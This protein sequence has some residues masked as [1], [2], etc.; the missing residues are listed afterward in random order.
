M[1]SVLATV[2]LLLATVCTAVAAT[3][4][5]AHEHVLNRARVG[6]VAAASLSDPV[7]RGE[8][9]RSAFPEYD[10][11]PAAY[12]AEVDRVSKSREF[13]RAVGAVRVDSRGRANLRPVRTALARN[14]DEHGYSDLVSRMDDSRVPVSIRL[15]PRIWES[16]TSARE[17][18][19]LV[20]VRAS[21][22]AGLLYVA[23]IAVARH[24]RRA[25]R[26]TGLGLLFGGAT[27]VALVW[28]S[29][30]LAGLATD[31]RLRAIAEAGRPRALDM[32]QSLLP[33]GIAGSLLLLGSLLMPRA[34]AGRP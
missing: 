28:F 34:R 3:A 9:L 19:W 24:R 32:V 15:P 29:P 13:E 30:V 4:Y 1:R 20:V 16:F 22:V 26:S 6:D 8:V 7:L 31:E 17:T 10:R 14:L 25:V 21:V 18:S 2:A 12:R 23:A 27:A 11:L 33:L 5:L